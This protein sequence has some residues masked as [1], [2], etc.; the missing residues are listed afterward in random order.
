MT[1]TDRVR[2]RLVL[3]VQAAE[4]AAYPPI[5]HAVGLMAEAG[6]RVCVLS[7][8]IAGMNL[9]FPPHMGIELRRTAPRPS[10]VMTKAAYAAYAAATAGLAIGRRPDIVY[11]S[12]PLGAGPGLLAARLSGARLVYHEHDTPNP[13]RCTPGW[14]ASAE[15]RRAGPA[16]VIFPNEARSRVARDELG[17]SGQPAAYRLEHAAPLRVAGAQAGAGRPAASLLSRQRLACSIASY[18]H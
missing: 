16:A 8:P 18:R 3:F 9:E 15:R 5:I 2:R 1:V 7:A 13:G 17:I 10:H 6:W 14:R 4:A 12:D 11:A